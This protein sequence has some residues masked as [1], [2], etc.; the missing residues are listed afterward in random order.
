MAEYRTML[1]GPVMDPVMGAFSA[2][3]IT[4]LSRSVKAEL[5]SWHID[6]ERLIRL[7]PR[8]V[9]RHTLTKATY[10]PFAQLRLRSVFPL[11]DLKQQLM[12]ADRVALVGAANYILLVRRAP[13]TTRPPRRSWTTSRR[14]SRS[15]PSCR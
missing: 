11:L 2:G 8:S 15:W 1:D 13:R 14:T 6:P 12:E 9:F 7:N 10:E 4:G 5:T 3:P